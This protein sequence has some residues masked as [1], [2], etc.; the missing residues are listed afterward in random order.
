MQT[1]RASRRR[2]S[3]LSVEDPLDKVDAACLGARAAGDQLC[4]VS[5]RLSNGPQCHWRNLSPARLL[6]FVDAIQG[7]GVFPLDVEQ[8]HI[9]ALAAD[10]HKWLLGPEGCGVLYVRRDAQDGILRVG[11][12]SIC[13]VPRLRLA[14]LTPPSRCWPI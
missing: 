2:R 7:L 10:G 8:A 4:A 12:T 13:Q 14:R 9:D 11:W 6:F 1:V 5:E 3:W